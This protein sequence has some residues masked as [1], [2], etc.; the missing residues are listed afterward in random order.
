MEKPYKILYGFSFIN[1]ARNSS[2]I[3][4]NLFYDATSHWLYRFFLKFQDGGI[5]F[6]RIL[7]AEKSRVIFWYLCYTQLKSD[8]VTEKY[9]EI[10]L[11]RRQWSLVV[12][13]R[14]GILPISLETGRYFRIPIEMR[15]CKICK[16]N[17]IEDAVHF[18]ASVV[19][20]YERQ[21]LLS[22]TSI[23]LCKYWSLSEIETFFYLLCQ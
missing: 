20:I 8:I 2:E 21:Q 16:Q 6:R 5:F 1:W 13:L 15:Y 4:N 10:N 18:Y 19:N 22:N 17:I 9:L 14:L 11:T 7:A 3:L 12:Q 23:S